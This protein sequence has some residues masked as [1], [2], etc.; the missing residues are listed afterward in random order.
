MHDELRPIFDRVAGPG[1]LVAIAANSIR[2]Q[3][4]KAQRKR[5]GLGRVQRELLAHCPTKPTPFGPM[6]TPTAA[7]AE[8]TDSLR[9]AAR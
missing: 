1:M 5:W 3:M 4:T 9:P 8:F 7:G 6:L 2:R